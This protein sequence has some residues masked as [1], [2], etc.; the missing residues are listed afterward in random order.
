MSL[1]HDALDRARADVN[2][3]ERPVRVS[4][5]G[6]GRKRAENPQTGDHGQ[7]VSQGIVVAI[8]LLLAGGGALIGLLYAFDVPG[9][10]SDTMAA[11]GPTAAGVLGGVADIAGDGKPGQEEAA[12]VAAVSGPVAD[13]GVAGTDKAS[14]DQSAAV[15]QKRFQTPFASGESTGAD[16][17]HEAVPRA[18][19]TDATG[20]GDSLPWVKKVP[21]PSAAEL[22]Q[23]TFV[24][25]IDHPAV[26][27]LQLQG[28]SWSPE[29]SV[30][31]INDGLLRRGDM[32]A[33]C[34]VIGIRR[35]RVTLQIDGAT[36]A[37]RI[38]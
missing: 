28:V 34:K 8:L 31:M 36:F 37:L 35:N 30:A 24:K 3:V 10:M 20:L 12:I 14:V 13:V 17:A 19:V 18:T 29:R 15:T 2:R 9:W 32:V 5:Y 27:R 26:G 22:H 25:V 16:V 1:I 7:S 21:A 6:G 23:Q 4:A 11:N 38:P 33:G